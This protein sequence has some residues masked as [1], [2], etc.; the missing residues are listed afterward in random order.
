MSQDTLA[1]ITEQFRLSI[2][3]LYRALL[4]AGPIITRQLEVIES[5]RFLGNILL[6]VCFLTVM[7]VLLKTHKD[8]QGVKKITEIQI[9]KRWLILMSTVFVFSLGVFNVYPGLALMQLDNMVS[10]EEA[11]ESE[12]WLN[13]DE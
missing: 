11:L 6:F 13:Y 5:F 3:L 8:V 4:N 1:A 10:S 12:I 7:F 9:K 2:A